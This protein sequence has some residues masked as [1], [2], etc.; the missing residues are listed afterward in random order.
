[1]IERFYFIALLTLCLTS[2]RG[3]QYLFMTYNVENLFDCHDDSL[4]DDN[5]FLPDGSRHW[6]EY[7]LQKKIYDIARVIVGA[8]PTQPFTAIGLCEVENDSVLMRLTCGPLRRFGYRIIHHN[9]PDRRG[10]DVAMLYNPKH[11]KPLRTHFLPVTYP[12]DTSFRTRDI[13]YCE[14]L[15]TNLHRIHIIIAHLPS[16]R[17]DNNDSDL[18]RQAA[19]EI[20]KNLCDSII[21]D[22]SN[23][24]I[25]ISGDF[26]CAP[27]NRLYRRALLNDGLLTDLMDKYIGTPQ[28]TY[29][30]QGQY[31]CLDH[32]VVS[33]TMTDSIASS[34]LK[35]DTI[36][37]DIVTL[38]WM[39]DKP[40][41]LDIRY[42][43]RTFRGPYYHGGI[44]DHLPVITTLTSK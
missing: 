41:S 40:N 15:L 13:L 18:K 34:T 11:L 44:S 26:N 36:S 33:T 23:A 9:S 14:A 8:S 38:P 19:F 25:L 7:R 24:N 21:T 42:P 31:S 1:M 6:T 12:A 43:Y 22:N 10:I 30:F 4:H 2:L 37:T 16:Q 20:I 28:G 17:S 39:L 3:E 35:A 29:C 5:E 27:D 32:F